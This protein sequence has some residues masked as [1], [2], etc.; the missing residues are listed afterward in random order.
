MREPRLLALRVTVPE[1]DWVTL[2]VRVAQLERES[3]KVGDGEMH[4]EGEGEAVAQGE[5][6]W[7]NVPVEHS[8]GEREPLGEAV[9][10]GHPVDER[11]CVLVALRHL[12]AVGERVPVPVVLHDS[13][14]VGVTLGDVETVCERVALGDTEAK[15]EGLR[16]YEGEVLSEGETLVEEDWEGVKDWEGETVAVPPFPPPPRAP[17]A[18]PDLLPV[19][20]REGEVLW[21]GLWEG[22][23]EWLEEGDSDALPE[24]LSD[25]VPVAVAARGSEGVRETLTLA[26]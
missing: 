23:P 24:A 11:E 20:L 8:V 14:E 9:S 21:E 26:V 2:L 25:G 3:V 13:E 19:E 22:L 1:R 7:L 12:L 16:E 18:D 6:L 5:A 15:R 17:T 10:E 4:D